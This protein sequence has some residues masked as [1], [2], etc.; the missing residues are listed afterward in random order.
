MG[1]RLCEVVKDDEALDFDA[2]AQQPCGKLSRHDA[3]TWAAK[4]LCALPHAQ[5]DRAKASSLHVCTLGA[6][7]QPHRDGADDTQ[8]VATLSSW[9]APWTCP[10]WRRR[11]EAL[12]RCVRRSSAQA[13]SGGNFADLP[14]AMNYQQSP[15]LSAPLFYREC[16]KPGFFLTLST[17]AFVVFESAPFPQLDLT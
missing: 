1:L 12:R 13:H 2:L 17:K 9:P 7:G 16:Y 3:M 10:E 15:L 8:A 11:R 14:Q 6:T 5:G 4:A